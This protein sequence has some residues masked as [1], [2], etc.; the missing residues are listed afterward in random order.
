L[1][2]SQKALSY[3]TRSLDIVPTYETMREYISNLS[4]IVDPRCLATI[5][6]ELDQSPEDQSYVNFLNR[7]YAY[8]LIEYGKLDEAEVILKRLLESPENEKFA[9]QELDYIES[10]RKEE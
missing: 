9:R 7:R 3:L 1:N 4:N 5:K 10:L 8:A 6:A 2:Q